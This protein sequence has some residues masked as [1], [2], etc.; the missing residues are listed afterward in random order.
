[1]GI[2]SLTK[3]EFEKLSKKFFNLYARDQMDVYVRKVK[4]REEK[5]YQRYLKKGIIVTICC[6]KT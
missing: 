2:K 1:M 4:K 5:S 3:S 6:M